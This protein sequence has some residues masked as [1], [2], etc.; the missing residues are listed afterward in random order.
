MDDEEERRI[1]SPNLLT[2][3]PVLYVANVEEGWDQDSSLLSWGEGEGPFS[4]ADSVV[5]LS[6]ALESELALL[7]EE[8]QREF[9]EALGGEQGRVPVVVLTAMDLTEEDLQRLNG[10]VQGVMEKGRT[11]SEELVAR[12][13]DALGGHAR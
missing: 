12:L 3:K 2:A 5:P 1:R 10:G 7:P 11:G 9:L 13:R 4:D 6:L 8:E